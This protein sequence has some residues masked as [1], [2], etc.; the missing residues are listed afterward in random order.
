[1]LMHPLHTVPHLK[2]ITTSQEPSIS[3][4]EAAHY[5]EKYLSWQAKQQLH[6]IVSV[7]IQIF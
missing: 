4:S 2:G 3:M 5:L 1:M 7:C 6:V